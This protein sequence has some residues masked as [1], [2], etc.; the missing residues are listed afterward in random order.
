VTAL[1]DRDLP[2]GPIPAQADEPAGIDGDLQVEIS[3]V[4][5]GDLGR[6]RGDDG[7]TKRG[8]PMPAW[9]S[10]PNRVPAA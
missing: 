4:E 1:A 5:S 9:P 3:L 10:W 8:W 2:I 6:A 7:R